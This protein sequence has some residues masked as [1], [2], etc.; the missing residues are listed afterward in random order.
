MRSFFSAMAFLTIL[1]VPGKGR[2]VGTVTLSWFPVVGLFLGGL[3]FLGNL[4]VHDV[5]PRQITS[6]LSVLF[7][8]VITG[9]LHLDGLADTADGLFS[10]RSREEA[11]RIMKTSDIGAMGAMALFFFLGMKWAAIASLPCEGWSSWA[12]FVLP[13]A[14]GRAA[15]V[16]GTYF[17]PYAR[18]EGTGK[19]FVARGRKIARF[20]PVLV[21]AGLP[22]IDGVR[23]FLG[24]NAVFLVFTAT[25]YV[26]YKKTIG[27][28]TGD[29]LGAWCEVTET[30]LFVT[31][32]VL[33]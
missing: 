7:L 24:L 31:A 22:L 11:L 14:Y 5:L 1:P 17:L 28:V 27:G 12:A 30:V 19:D 10:H 26:F 21:L 29:L 18:K 4:L 2:M 13:P 6:L 8:A 9:G 33:R 15:M 25:V 16:F 3:L 23:L 32:G 20:L